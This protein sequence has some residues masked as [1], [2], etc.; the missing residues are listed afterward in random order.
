[1]LISVQIESG[2]QGNFDLAENRTRS[3]SQFYRGRGTWIYSQR[4]NFQAEANGYCQDF[5]RFREDLRG[6]INDKVYEIKKEN[7]EAKIIFL[8]KVRHN[9]IRKLKFFVAIVEL[10]I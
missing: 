10:N 7:K 3:S 1:M 5:Q 4:G 9:L 2:K 6:K 8:R